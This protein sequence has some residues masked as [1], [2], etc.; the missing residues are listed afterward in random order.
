[1]RRNTEEIYRSWRFVIASAPLL[2]CLF[3]NQ[4][5]AT[6]W[7][8]GER[9]NLPQEGKNYCAAGDFRHSESRLQKKLALLLKKHGGNTLLNETRDVFSANRD[10]HCA[11]KNVH[12]KDKPYY[13]MVVAQCKTRLNN[14]RIEELENMQ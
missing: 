7:E 14:Q 11:S 9:S 8:C 2:A 3:S 6:L 10:D 13:P 5:T 12:N 1:M 4:A